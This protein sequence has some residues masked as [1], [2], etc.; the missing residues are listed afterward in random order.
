MAYPELDPDE[1]IIL[2]TRNVKF[3]TISFDAIL[4]SKRIILMD[5][6]K[7]VLPSHEISLEAI[8]NVETGENAIRDHFLILTTI[9]GTGEKHD[10]V[11]T[12]LR[13]SGGERKRE[14]NEWAKK[15][16]NLIP[17]VSQESV[18]CD[19]RA[20]DGGILPTRE[21]TAPA[22]SS[23]TIP[24]PEKK[25]IEI[26]RPLGKI[27]DESP[28]SPIP[29]E[30]SS[31]PSGTFCSRCGN[32][33]PYESTYC[34]HCGT[35][36]KHQAV[37]VPAPK[38]VVPQVQIPVPPSSVSSTKQQVRPIEQIIHSIE[39]LIEDSVPRTHPFLLYEKTPTEK[40]A[41]PA[42]A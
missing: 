22:R 34:N 21:S 25:G 36:I 33:V 41:E 15:L 38:P 14:C 18:P 1:S 37:H 8:R 32:R 19:T 29:I 26:A 39:P 31:L 9:T 40:T 35:P 7:N 20:P 27:R 3:K 28:V 24:R 13:Q 6:K 12:F 10:I 42:P 11:L 5:S 30:T 2:E 17:P 23:K 16:K 4:T